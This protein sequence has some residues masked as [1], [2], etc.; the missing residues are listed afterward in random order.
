MLNES[1]IIPNA[2]KPPTTPPTI[3]AMLE[4]LSKGTK[5]VCVCVCMCLKRNRWE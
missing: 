2:T 4:L 3:V 5:G 1:T